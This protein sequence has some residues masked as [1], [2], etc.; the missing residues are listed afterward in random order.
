MI[1]FG[2]SGQEMK[3]SPMDYATIHFTYPK[4]LQY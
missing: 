1:F 4:T 3:M 2:I